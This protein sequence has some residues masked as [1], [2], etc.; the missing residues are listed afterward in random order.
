MRFGILGTGNVGQTIGS[1][2]CSLGY[3]VRLGAR[4]AGN[5]WFLGALTNSEPRGTDSDSTSGRVRRG[6]SRPR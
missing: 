1:K 2:L 4:Q 3:E 6:C 5:E